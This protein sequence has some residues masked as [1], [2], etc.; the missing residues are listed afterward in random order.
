MQHERASG[1]RSWVLIAAVLGLALVPKR[2]HEQVHEQVPERVHERVPKFPP[3]AAYVLSQKR[4]SIDTYLQIGISWFVIVF[5]T[6]T[7]LSYCSRFNATWSIMSA[8]A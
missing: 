4:I 3:Y 2:L 1:A 7:L 6:I 5:R 8:G